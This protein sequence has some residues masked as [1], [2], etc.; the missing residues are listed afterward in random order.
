VYDSTSD[1]S[2]RLHA[3]KGKEHST[4][5]STGSK[6]V[7]FLLSKPVPNCICG[8]EHE[9]KFPRLELLPDAALLT[10]AM[11]KMGRPSACSTT[12][13]KVNRNIGLIDIAQMVQYI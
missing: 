10:F 11:L 9:P 3:K 2:N 1:F 6:L 12:E 13:M 5:W 7:S 4:L 8:T